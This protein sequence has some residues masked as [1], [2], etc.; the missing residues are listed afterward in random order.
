MAKDLN[1]VQFTGHL[2]ADP[3]MR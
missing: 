3:E 2:G 1:K